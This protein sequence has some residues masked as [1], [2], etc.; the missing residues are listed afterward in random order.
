MTRMKSKIILILLTVTFVVPMLTAWLSY[1]KGLLLTGKKVNHG[2]LLEHPVPISRLILMDNNGPIDDA[3]FKGKWWFV[4]LTESPQNTSSQRNLYYMR[5]IRQATGKDRDRI[6]RAILTL[7]GQDNIDDWL[8]KHYPGTFHF[9]ISSEKIGQLA[10]NLP[11]KL[12]LKK[13]SLYLVDPHG[14]I[15]LFYTPDAAPKGILK[16]LQRVLKVSQIG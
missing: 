8:Q 1:S 12:A 2:I 10:M 16:D 5:Q 9:T 15:M 3:K 14:N 6:E 11:K 7:P 13:G 4:Y